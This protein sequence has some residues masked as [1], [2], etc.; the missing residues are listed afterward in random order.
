V[1]LK[2]GVIAAESLNGN[3]QTN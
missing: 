1:T 2:T 3:V